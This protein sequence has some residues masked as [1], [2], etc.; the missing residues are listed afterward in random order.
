MRLKVISLLV[1][2][3]A[4]ALAW[5]WWSHRQGQGAQAMGQV[6]SA[7]QAEALAP[8]LHPSQR[9]TVVHFWATWCPPCMVEMPNMLAALRSVPAGV[10]VSLVS[11]DDP[12]P[13]AFYAREKIATVERAGETHVNWLNDP[14]Q[15]RAKAILGKVMLP[16]TLVLDRR[17]G[18][19]VQQ[20]DG[21]LDWPPLMA[22]LAG[23]V[24]HN[25]GDDDGN[26][27]E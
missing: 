17:N 6:P 13:V 25:Q 20:I 8:Y 24:D 16:T 14:Q 26:K 27:V 21:P 9:F 7:V 11:L 5:D 10:G 12:A 3:C 22:A 18:R 19:I 2:L 23:M 1:C 4:L 15:V